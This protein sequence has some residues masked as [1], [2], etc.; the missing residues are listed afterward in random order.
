MLWEFNHVACGFGRVREGTL[1]SECR[2]SVF[3][4]VFICCASVA[5]G[6]VLRCVSARFPKHDSHAAFFR[7][8]SAI[9]N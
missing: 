4:I 1:P 9:A 2:N 3:V 7:D 8:G 6:R 5:F